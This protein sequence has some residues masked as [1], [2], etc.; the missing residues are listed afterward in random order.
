[1]VEKE[2]LMIALLKMFPM[3][4]RLELYE[5]KAAVVG[6][7]VGFESLYVVCTSVYHRFERYTIMQQPFQT[8]RFREYF[9]N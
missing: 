9:V 8:N 7:V 1:M 4:R 6:D 5:Q 3:S 2:R